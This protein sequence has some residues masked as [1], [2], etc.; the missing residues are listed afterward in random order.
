MAV[1]FRHALARALAVCGMIAVGPMFAIPNATM[2]SETPSACAELR[3]W[4]EAYREVTPT[5]T[6]DDFGRLDR[7]HRVALFGAVTP[8]VRSA[9][10]QERLRR[11]AQEPNW[12]T[13]ER[14]LF[15]EA[16][17]FM[18][19]AFYEQSPDAIL[20]LRAFEKK[21]AAVFVTTA[22]KRVWYDL[23]NPF[24]SVLEV[25][26]IPW[27]DCNLDFQDCWGGAP[28]NGSPCKDFGPG[29]GFGGGFGCNGRC[30]S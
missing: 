26:Q 7:A 8:A 20:A 19:P 18:T 13:S 12:S 9:L 6:L 4:A 5:P 16:P 28:C 14:A 24:P 30:G 27:C 3:S 21:V 29:C 23:V 15:H 22:R 17:V 1:P 10:W 25:A 2:A 11:L